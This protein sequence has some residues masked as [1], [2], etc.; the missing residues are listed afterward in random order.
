MPWLS[1]IVN[2][3]AILNRLHDISSVALD[4]KGRKKATARH[5]RS[6]PLCGEHQTET[7]GHVERSS[8]SSSSAPCFVD[9]GCIKAIIS[10]QCQ[11]AQGGAYSDD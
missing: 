5:R 9:Y 8:S 1:G 7:A 11:L 10:T 6:A 3:I 4:E 2:A